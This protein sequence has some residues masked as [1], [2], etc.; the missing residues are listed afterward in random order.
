MLRFGAAS[1]QSKD[2]YFEHACFKNLDTVLKMY[3]SFDSVAARFAD[4]TPLRMAKLPQRKSAL[5]F[6]V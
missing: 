3:G 6:S 5:D 1:M 4:G 2:P